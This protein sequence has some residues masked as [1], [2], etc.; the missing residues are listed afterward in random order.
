MD[1]PYTKIVWVINQHSTETTRT[2]QSCTIIFRTF[3]KTFAR[4]LYHFRLEIGIA[5]YLGIFSCTNAS[6]FHSCP[7]IEELQLCIIE[8]LDQYLQTYGMASI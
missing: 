8:I 4:L 2:L 1:H 5:L 6:H 3:S 7:L